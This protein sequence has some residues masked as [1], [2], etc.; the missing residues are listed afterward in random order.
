[1]T[2]E[3]VVARIQTDFICTSS[4]VKCANSCQK[5]M[6]KI[7]LISSFAQR[8]RTGNSFDQHMTLALDTTEVQYN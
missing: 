6:F 4:T 8:N 5:S 3:N 2:P 7:L 1:M